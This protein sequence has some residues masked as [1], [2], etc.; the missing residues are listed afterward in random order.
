MKKFIVFTAV[1]AMALLTVA[2]LGQIGQTQTS[3]TT[4]QLLNRQTAEVPERSTT[5]AAFKIALNTASVPGGVIAVPSCDSEPVYTLASTSASLRDTL[6]TVVATDARYSWEIENGVV[7]LV[8]R[9][10]TPAFLNQRITEFRVENAETVYE[11]L[12]RLLALPEVQRSINELNLGSRLFRGGIGYF[13]PSRRTEERSGRRLT[14]I[15]ENVTLRE[16]LNAI[17]RAQGNAVWSYAEHRCGSNS[18]SIDFLV[19]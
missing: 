12:D 2:A 4:E 17:A 8:P 9:T 18:F 13:E 10:G 3:T 16:A 6:D 14:V 1:A 11:A 7:N 19:Q 5:R 15:C